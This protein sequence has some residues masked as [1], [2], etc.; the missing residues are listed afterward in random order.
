MCLLLFT[1]VCYKRCVLLQTCQGLRTL[2]GLLYFYMFICKFF[3]G[4]VIK[5]G[6]GG[7][8]NKNWFSYLS[9]FTLCVTIWVHVHWTSK[10]LIQAMPPLAI[11]LSESLIKATLAH[12]LPHSSTPSHASSNSA[13]CVHIVMCF[14]LLCVCYS[15]VC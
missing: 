10:S 2:H 8:V 12:V 7:G 3:W 13:Q 6:F 15:F 11:F 5:T 1:L 14:I 9:P 4:G